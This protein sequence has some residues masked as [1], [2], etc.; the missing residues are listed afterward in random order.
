MK[1][2]LL[3]IVALAFC[4]ITMAQHPQKSKPWIVKSVPATEIDNPVANPLQISNPSVNSKAVLEDDI[5]ATRYDVQTNAAI[6]NRIVLF[7]DGTIAGTWTRGTT[8]TSFTERGTGYNYFNGTTWGPQPSARI[9]TV[10]TGWPT[11]DAWNTGGEIVVSHQSATAPLIKC[12]RTTKGAGAWTQGT[13]ARPPDF[14]KEML[15][16]RLITN[17]PTHNYVHMIALS[18]P[19][20]NGGAIYKGLDGALLYYRSLNGGTTWDKQGIQLPGLDSASYTSFSGDE[21]AWG[22]PKGDTIY[23]VA[24][25]SYTDMF[26]MKST[27]NGENWTKINILSN[28]HKKIPA[29]VTY[30]APWASSDGAV[31]CEMDQQGIIHVASGIGGGSMSGGTKYISLYRNGLI[32]WNTTMSMIQDSLDLDTLNAHGQLL[33]YYFD[34]P[35]PGDTLNTMTSYRVGLTSFPQMSIDAYNNLFVIYAGITWENPDPSGINYHHIFGRAKYHD[36]ATWSTEPIDFNAGF[37]YYGQEYIFA[38]MTKRITND[39]LRIIYQTA[40]Q[41]GTAVGTTGVIPYH[42]CIIQYRE[43]TG[44]SFWPVGISDNS[45]LKKNQVSQ[46]YP[47]PVKGLTYFNVNLDQAS[48]VMVEISNIMGQKVLNF[49]KG[50][51]NAGMHQM[52]FDGSQL[53]PGIYFYTVRIRGEAFTHKMIVE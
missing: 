48:N 47:N 46:N 30:L 15:W 26:I 39:K 17:G 41:P 25:G 42:D 1:K 3:F 51:V 44:N 4:V 11:M 20:G 35:N 32:Y 45:L 19:T 5:G 21:Y 33:G 49:D 27:D 43:L 38:S 6:A 13:I 9:E 7:N 24:G 37:L 8:E 50:V 31:A 23:F 22:S 14:N 52:V 12:T 29:S 34:G 53:I 2:N 16:P 18:A 36:K 40:T 10:R 28:G